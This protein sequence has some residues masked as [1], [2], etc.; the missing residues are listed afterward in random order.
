MIKINLK[1]FL[2]AC[3]QIL[4]IVAN[5]AWPCSTSDAIQSMPQDS[6]I[7][8]I[9]SISPSGKLDNVVQSWINIKNTEVSAQPES[10]K[11]IYLCMHRV[12]VLIYLGVRQNLSQSFLMPA[13]LNGHP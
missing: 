5:P 2:Y 1:L 4:M 12:I 3:M 7:E 8:T 6:E 9:R 11:P 13:F 10:L